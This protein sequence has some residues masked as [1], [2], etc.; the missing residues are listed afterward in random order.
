MVNNSSANCLIVNNKYKHIWIHSVGGKVC[1]KFH[2]L[3]FADTQT[4]TKSWDELAEASDGGHQTDENKAGQTNK[5]SVWIFL[6]L[7]FFMD[8]L[9]LLLMTLIKNREYFVIM[10]SQNVDS[11]RNERRT[12]TIA[13]KGVRTQWFIHIDAR[14]PEQVSSRVCLVFWWSES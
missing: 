11:H 1:R 9:H 3:I 7:Y 10:Q 8:T 2:S 14:Q 5:S 4:Q 12:R 13:D 6:P